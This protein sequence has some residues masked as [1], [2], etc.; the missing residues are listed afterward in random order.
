[1][2]K[3]QL[4]NKAKKR[5]EGFANIFANKINDDNIPYARQIELN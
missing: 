2:K 3:K 4:F 5:I 1:M